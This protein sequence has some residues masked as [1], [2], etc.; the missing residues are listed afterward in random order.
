M[1]FHLLY[2]YDFPFYVTRQ[3]P[4]MFSAFF[5][6]LQITM[7]KCRKIYPNCSWH[8]PLEWFGLIFNSALL[9]KVCWNY[10]THFVCVCVSRIYAINPQ[11][12]CSKCNLLVEFGSKTTP[13]L[14]EHL[15]NYSFTN[16]D[17]L[18]EEML[19]YLPT[20]FPSHIFDFIAY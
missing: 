12:H 13:S 19:S 16:N 17:S 18:L 1:I 11:L 5:I 6:L 7:P 15:G 4:I 14:Y 9:T 2:W 8:V 3:V 10:A 20:R